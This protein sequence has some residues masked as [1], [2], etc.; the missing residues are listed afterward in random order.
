MRRM[1]KLIGIVLL[2]GVLASGALVF[3]GGMIYLWR[4]GSSQVHY[5]VFR[6]EPSDLRSIS[7][8]LEDVKGGSGRGL[9]QSG[10][11]LLV[12]VQLVR[13]ALTGILFGVSRD[14]PFVMIST[15]V[16]ALLTYALFFAG[17]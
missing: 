5:R 15:L 13:V 1:E 4:H 3:S 12:A 6:G 17:H 11:I 10:L 8:I 7:G 9:I 16:L 2:T 14:K